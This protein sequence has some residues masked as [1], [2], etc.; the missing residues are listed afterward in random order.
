MLKTT[1]AVSI[2]EVRRG[3]SRRPLH[4]AIEFQLTSD[5]RRELQL[6][7]AGNHRVEDISRIQHHGP[8]SRSCMATCT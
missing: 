6:G 1:R 3:S 2:W 7:E 8:P 5:D 4:P